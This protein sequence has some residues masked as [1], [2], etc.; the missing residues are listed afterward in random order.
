[1]LLPV[2]LPAQ[3]LCDSRPGTH[4]LDRAEREKNAADILRQTEAQ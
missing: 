4:G 2:E 3:C 1:M